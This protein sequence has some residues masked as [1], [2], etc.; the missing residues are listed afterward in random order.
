[1]PD[2]EPTDGRDI[3]DWKE[4]IRVQMGKGGEERVVR[5]TLTPR[6]RPMP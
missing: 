2:A 1:M 3:L 5:L 6:C 4:H